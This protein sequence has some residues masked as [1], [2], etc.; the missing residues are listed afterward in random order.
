MPQN[1]HRSQLSSAYCTTSR[2]GGDV[3]TSCTLLLG[4]ASIDDAGPVVSTAMSA[5]PLL[6]LRHSVSVSASS[7]RDFF[8][9]MPRTSRVGGTW[10]RLALI[11]RWAATLVAWLGGSV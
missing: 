5:I 3:T 8:S 9:R 2:N 1:Q 7:A 4:T 11:L 10:L 6:R